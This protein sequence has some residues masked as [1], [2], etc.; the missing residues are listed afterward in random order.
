VLV[1]PFAGHARWPV[2]EDDRRKRNVG[3]ALQ[4]GVGID[5]LGKR[6]GSPDVLADKRLHAPHSELSDHEPKLERTKPAAQ[7]YPIIHKVYDPFAV[8][9]LK[10]VGNV[11]EGPPQQIRAP[12]VERGAI[13]G[14]EQPFVGIHHHRIGLVASVENMPHFR[15]DRSG[16]SI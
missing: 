11:L 3:Q 6:A 2:P 8:V 7:G 13:H 12:S 16:S 14:R 10:I 4:L 9:A 1:E 5:P 15:E